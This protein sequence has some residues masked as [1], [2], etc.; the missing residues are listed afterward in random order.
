[1]TNVADDE[2]DDLGLGL[3]DLLDRSVNVAGRADER[4]TRNV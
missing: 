3:D 4:P 1:M 2:K